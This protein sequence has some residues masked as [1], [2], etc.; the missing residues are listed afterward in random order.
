V[1][2]PD[3]DRDDG[4]EAKVAA[5]AHAW[6]GHLIDL[7]RRNNL[8]YFRDLKSGTLD[9]A[10]ADSEQRERLLMGERVRA[11]KLFP[12]ESELRLT[13]R[14]LTEI[15]RRIR[16]LSEERGIDAGYIA[17]GMLGWPAPQGVG[18]TA[19]TRSLILL[20]PLSITVKGANA[21]DF[22][23]VVN[24]EAEINPVLLYAL[25]KQ[26]GVETDG[27]AEELEAVAVSERLARAVA[28]LQ[29]R[30]TAAGVRLDL[31]DKTVAAV[32]AYEKMPMVRDLE[33][34]LDL[35]AGHDLVA[36]LAGARDA[37]RALQRRS[38]SS[39]FDPNGVDPATEYLVLDADTSQQSAIA[40][41]LAGHDLIVQ[42]P[43]GTGKSQTIANLITEAVSHGKKVLFVAQKRAAID[44]VVNNLRK[45]DLADIVLDLHDPKTSRKA[46]VEQLRVSMEQAGLAPPVD[47]RGPHRTLV[48]RRRQLQQHSEIMT[49]IRQPSGCSIADLEQR[50]L[51]APPERDL[52]ITLSQTTLSMISSEDLSLLEDD[53][54]QFVES[55]GLRLWRGESPWSRAREIVGQAELQAVRSRLDELTGRGLE[56]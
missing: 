22:E 35:L 15:R 8:L 33:Q 36:A 14:R 11:S 2:V 48:E 30:A 55:D 53:L 6:A 12:D 17:L 54:K 40:A 46:V 9:L 19:M 1:A 37:R 38:E 10:G 31:Q 42:G 28:L 29:E 32:F 13:R 39:D 26:A 16:M 27:I 56:E 4:R 18:G 51:S 47:V 52:G 5:A 41:A 25:R 44:A 34:S 3:V 21:A 50:L 7:S 20:R 23:L 49:T 43:P 45:H 24:E